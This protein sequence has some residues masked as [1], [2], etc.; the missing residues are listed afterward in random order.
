[1]QTATNPTTSGRIAASL[2]LQVDFHCTVQA[3]FVQC[4]AS[5]ST[6]LT[7]EVSCGFIGRSIPEGRARDG[8]CIFKKLGR[9][10]DPSWPFERQLHMS[11]A[12]FDAIAPPHLGL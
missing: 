9:S 10:L 12:G 1:M 6:R 8:V 7:I 2:H 11:F 3:G 4:T 5:T